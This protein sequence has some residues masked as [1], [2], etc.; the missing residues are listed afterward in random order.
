VGSGRTCAD[1][2]CVRSD[3]Y[4][5]TADHRLVLDAVCEG[6]PPVIDL[7]KEYKKVSGLDKLL[8]AVHVPPRNVPFL[9]GRTT[10]TRP[11]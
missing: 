9:E 2:L 5:T 6:K 8:A 11:A 7:S 3:A 4:V 10:Q 1:L